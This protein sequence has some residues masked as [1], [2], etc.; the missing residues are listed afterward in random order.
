MIAFG[1][2]SIAYIFTGLL[3][4]LD[5]FIVASTNG[6]LPLFIINNN[7]NYLLDMN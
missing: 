1:F 4:S 7:I 2:F 3:D 6:P 5:A